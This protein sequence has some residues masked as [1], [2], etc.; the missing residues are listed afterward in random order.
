M[1]TLKVN[2]ISPQSGGTVT[3]DGSLTET[4]ALRY[5]ENVQDLE[6][7]SKVMQLR[8]VTFDWKKD[9]KHDIGLIAEE[10]A[11]LYPELVETNGDITGVKYTKLTALLIKTV[12][13]QNARIEKLETQISTLN[14]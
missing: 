11:E 4:S 7:T 14:S 12:Q 5:K 6:D 8:P 9:Q 2:T 13:E 3:I 1:S 10:V